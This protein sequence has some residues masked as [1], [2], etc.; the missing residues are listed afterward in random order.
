MLTIS[1]RMDAAAGNDAGCT[2]DDDQFSQG[3]AA[4][5]D[6]FVLAFYAVEQLILRELLQFDS[7]GKLA[8]FFPQGFLPTS[9]YLQFSDAACATSALPSGG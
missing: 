6:G 8:V 9:L 2:A 1:R 7:H 4:V 5:A 3:V